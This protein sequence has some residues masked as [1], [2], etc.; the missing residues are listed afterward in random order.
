MA[1]IEAVITLTDI[2][3]I[4]KQIVARFQPEKVI[5][6]GSYARQT[7]VTADSDVDLLVLM[8]TDEQPLQTAARIAAAVDHP[9]P[10]DIIVSTPT[11]FEAS[12]ARR[13][14]FATQ[15]AKEG[16]VLYEA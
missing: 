7:A 1:Q 3:H 16:V 10:L 8:E 9:F 2:Q 6:F 12:L 15:V 11:D 4:V 14:N 5:L 13:G